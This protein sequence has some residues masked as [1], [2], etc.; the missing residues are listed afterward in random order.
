MAGRRPNAW[1]HEVVQSGEAHGRRQGE[2]E[3]KRE[4]GA[5]HSPLSFSTAKVKGSHRGGR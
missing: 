1:T 2:R 3:G 4:F 5:P